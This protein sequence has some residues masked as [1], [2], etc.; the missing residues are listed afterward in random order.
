MGESVRG[1]V[2]DAARKVG[3]E[4]NVVQEVTDIRLLLGLTSAELGITF[5]F[6]H[7]R[8]LRLRN[9][10]YLTVMPA[11][12]LAFGAVYRR[13]FGGTALAPLLQRIAREE[14]G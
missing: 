7:N 13:G 14:Q 4:P 5:V 8:D 2:T 12:S 1:Y 9:I 10:H 6:T 3:F 11:I